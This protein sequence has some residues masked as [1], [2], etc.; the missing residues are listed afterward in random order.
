MYWIYGIGSYYFLHENMTINLLKNCMKEIKINT[1]TQD[2]K[3]LAW[4][5]YVNDNIIELDNI[6]IKKSVINYRVSVYIYYNFF[7]MCYENDFSK[8]FEYLLSIGYNKY[9]LNK[10]ENSKIIKFFNI[11]LQNNISIEDSILIIS[12]LNKN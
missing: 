12:E 7:D 5:M 4:L 9:K 6:R 10:K 3:M 2:D 1:L 11:L 8:S